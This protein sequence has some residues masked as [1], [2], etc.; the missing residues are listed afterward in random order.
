M[1]KPGVQPVQLLLQGFGN[2]FRIALDRTSSQVPLDC[3]C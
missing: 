3:C 2:L 1:G